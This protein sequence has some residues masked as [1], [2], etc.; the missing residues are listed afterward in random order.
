MSQWTSQIRAKLANRL[1]EDYRFLQDRNHTLFQ[2]ESD[3]REELTNPET[4][5][6]PLILCLRPLY[7]PPGEE[8][9]P[10]FDVEMKCCIELVSLICDDIQDCDDPYWQELYC[11]YGLWQ[12][13]VSS[14]ILGGVWIGAS[15]MLSIDDDFI[16]AH[17]AANMLLP[18][19]FGTANR[20][21]WDAAITRCLE[22]LNKRGGARS[23][24]GHKLETKQ[25]KNKR[26]TTLAE[27]R[28]EF[29]PKAFEHLCSSGT[30]SFMSFLS[31]QVGKDSQEE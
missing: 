23:I 9:P 8:A 22:I 13:S 4:T 14:E 19:I 30:N 26:P 27:F 24:F 12:G 31:E 29:V 6:L 10:V 15:M 28:Q 17:H 20:E 18:L 7:L 3:F 16:A 2:E 21:N 1:Q 25:G 5:L 11:M